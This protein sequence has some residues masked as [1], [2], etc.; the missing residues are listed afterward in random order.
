M[1]FIL[2]GKAQTTWTVIRKF[3]YNDDLNF[4][5]SYL[6]PKYFT[7]NIVLIEMFLHYFF[8]FSLK[9]DKHCTIELS[10]KGEHFFSRLFETHDKDRDD[11]LSPVELKSLFSM[12]T[13]EPK[14]LRQ[15]LY[16]TNHKVKLK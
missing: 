5:Y 7:L 13:E 9:V 3:G 11:C 12:C 8:L 15:C 10:H 1:L 6:Q 2:K 4:S 16:N 14:L